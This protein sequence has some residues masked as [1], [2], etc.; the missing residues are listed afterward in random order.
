MNGAAALQTDHSSGEPLLLD[1]RS[2][3]L[4]TSDLEQVITHCNPPAAGAS[5]PSREDAIDRKV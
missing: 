5:S 4:S 3:F 2:A 1:G